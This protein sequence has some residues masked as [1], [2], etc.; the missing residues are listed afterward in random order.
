MLLVLRSKAQPPVSIQQP[1]GR[2]LSIVMLR[3]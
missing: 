2:A 1:P 3:N